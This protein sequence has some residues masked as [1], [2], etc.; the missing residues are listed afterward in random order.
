MIP[1]SVT[2]IEGVTWSGTGAFNGCTGLTEIWFMG[3]T[4]PSIN[5]YA[6]D[7]VTETIPLYYPKGCLSS[8]TYNRF[9]NKIPFS[10]FTGA[11]DSNWGESDNW[12]YGVPESTVAALIEAVATITSNAQAKHVAFTDGKYIIID[13]GQLT[14]NSIASHDVNTVTIRNDGQLI[15]NTAVQGT[16]QKTIAAYTSN[17]DGWNFIAS[18]VTE[19]LGYNDVPG[20]LPTNADEYD[21]YYLEEETTM[22]RNFKPGNTYSVFNI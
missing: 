13:G 9:A 3:T 4:Q 12:A 20:L 10:L 14:C 6:F 2:S 7:G 19:T 1:A 17:N 22:W 18:P 5:Q 21:L 15:C 16:V 11:S 8:Y